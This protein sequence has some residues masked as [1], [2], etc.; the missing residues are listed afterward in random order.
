VLKN[1]NRIVSFDSI[2]QMISAYNRGS[3][4]RFLGAE[5]VV[6]PYILDRKIKEAPLLTTF[7]KN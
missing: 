5:P 4:N 1:G 7:S 3:L 2:Q 6:K